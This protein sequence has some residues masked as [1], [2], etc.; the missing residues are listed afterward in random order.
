MD[1]N[2][3]LIVLRPFLDEHQRLTALPV[4][5][6]KKLPA[7]YYLAGKFK[8]DRNYSEG[9]VNDI[10]DSWSTFHDPATLRRELFNHHL[11]N[12]TSDCA[13]YWLEADIPELP[14]F[15]AKYL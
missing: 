12:R 11:L 7:L 2:S 15:I 10:L 14:E 1:T 4:K 9:E 3:A 6:R 8:A 13:R 5:Q